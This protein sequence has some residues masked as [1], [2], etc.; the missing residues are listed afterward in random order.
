MHHDKNQSK[1][2]FLQLDYTS[3]L[4]ICWHFT[5]SSLLAQTDEHRCT[6]TLLLPQRDLKSQLSIRWRFHTFS[7]VIAIHSLAKHTPLIP[8]SN[9]QCLPGTKSMSPK[10]GDRRQQREKVVAPKPNKLRL[11]KACPLHSQKLRRTNDQRGARNL[12]STIASRWGRKL[13]A[14]PSTALG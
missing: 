7:K 14:H 13:T 10:R 9:F 4:S 6:S 11:L 5:L 12:A 1:V 2:L 3:L 8:Y